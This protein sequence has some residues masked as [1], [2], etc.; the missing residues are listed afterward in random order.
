MLKTI[1]VIS[2]KVKHSQCLSLLTEFAI[3]KILTAEFYVRAARDPKTT[4]LRI[5]FHI[6]KLTESEWF[7]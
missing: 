6:A 3:G 1:T 7:L 5:V 2:T 4:R